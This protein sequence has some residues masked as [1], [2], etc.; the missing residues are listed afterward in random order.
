MAFRKEKFD[1]LRLTAIDTGEVTEI[2]RYLFLSTQHYTQM[3]RKT[4]SAN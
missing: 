2:D 4:D 1:T 3:Q